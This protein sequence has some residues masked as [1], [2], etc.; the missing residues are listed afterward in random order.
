[1][2]LLPDIGY[3]TEGYPAKVAQGLRVLNATAW[4]GAL[5]VLG[6]AIYDAWRPKLWTL[7]GINLLT[8]LFLLAIPL[9][10]RFGALAAPLAYVIFMFAVIFVVCSMLGTDSGMQIQYLAIAAGF[11]LVVGADRVGLIAAIN[12]IAILLF[13]ALEILVPHDTGLLTRREMLEN[14]VGCIVGTSAILFA[15]VFY[16]IRQI[17]RAEATAEREH[18][19]SEAL[20]ANILPVSVVG[21]LKQPTKAEIADKYDDA[22]VL[23][24]DMAGFTARAS[25]SS[26][27]ELVRFLNEVYTLL[28]GLVE[29]HGLEKIKTS[30]DAYMVVSGVPEPLADHAG[31]LADLALDMRDA[32]LKL[33][34]REVAVPMRIGIASGPVVAGVVGTRKFFYDVWGDTV[35]MAS[36]M[37]ST[38][39]SGM[40]QVAPQTHD[41][42]AGRYTL[43][44]R[45]LVDVRGK[46]AVRT[47]FLVGRDPMPDHLSRR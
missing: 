26:P 5:L 31:A 7:A 15:I 28:D 20:L 35:N 22:S 33:G 10:H 25:D 4:C 2:R 27:E 41:L 34:G 23:F 14:F 37:E 40:I 36:R 30:G 21:R 1:M 11:V 39:M 42:I 29:R 45:G 32:L 17:A 3:G 18:Q 16:A 38:G 43:K 19:R 12:V 9:W 6:F 24:A 44:E 47:W 8:F 13:I 46:G